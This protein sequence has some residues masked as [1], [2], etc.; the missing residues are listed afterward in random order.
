LVPEERAE[1]TRTR[2]VNE[3]RISTRVTP[4]EPGLLS[5]VKQA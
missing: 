2:M 4:E 5:L 1:V 3:T